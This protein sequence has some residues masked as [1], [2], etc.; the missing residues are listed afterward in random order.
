MLEISSLN[1]SGLILSRIPATVTF[2]GFG[3]G[4]ARARSWLLPHSIDT[5]F[6]NP[7]PFGMRPFNPRP[8]FCVR[9]S[10]KNSL[11]LSPASRASSPNKGNPKYNQRI[12]DAGHQTGIRIRKQRNPMFPGASCGCIFRIHLTDTYRLRLAGDNRCIRAQARRTP[13]HT[14][15]RYV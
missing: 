6:I 4:R 15:R 10:L 9:N 11:P 2:G 3:G 12:S 8:I 14:D 5:W 7:R 13:I 1:A